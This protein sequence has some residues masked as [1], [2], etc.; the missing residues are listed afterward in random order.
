M[1]KDPREHVWLIPGLLQTLPDLLLSG[2][3]HSLF[4]GL[5]LHL[6]G[7]GNSSGHRLRM[8]CWGYFLVNG[9]VKRVKRRSNSSRATTRQRKAESKTGAAAGRQL[10]R[11]TRTGRPTPAGVRKI[12]VATSK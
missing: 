12:R 8:A 10:R 4:H 5:L 2:C 3:P 1:L 7:Q 11:A 6:T 9:L